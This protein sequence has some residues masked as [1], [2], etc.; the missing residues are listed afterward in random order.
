MKQPGTIRLV[1]I[2]LLGVPSYLGHSRP[3]L[4]TLWRI[5]L[6]DGGEGSLP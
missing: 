3:E 6:A 5:E 4:R 1:P 2:W